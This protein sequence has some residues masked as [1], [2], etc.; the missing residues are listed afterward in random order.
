MQENRSQ[1]D[2][3][4][5]FFSSSSTTTTTTT[6]TTTRCM[7]YME[8]FDSL[9]SCI[10]VSHHSRQV[11]WMALSVCIELGNINFSSLTILVCPYVGV[12]RRMLLMSSFLHFQQ[13]SS[14]SCSSYLDSCLFEGKGL[15]SCF[16]V[17]CCFQDLFKTAC[18][19]FV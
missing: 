13:C 2:S 4:C 11:L 1:F 8:S 7:D 15:Y 18:S 9:L 12:H 14:M 19:I 5:S 3:L 17:G 16:F 10:P 6:T